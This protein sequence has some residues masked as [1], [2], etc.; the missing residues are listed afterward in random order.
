MLL[1]V[2]GYRRKGRVSRIRAREILELETS[3]DSGRSLEPEV[4]LLRPIQGVRF[5]AV[6]A[7]GFACTGLSVLH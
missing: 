3:F 7:I 5:L 1:V 2:I 4:D 6:D